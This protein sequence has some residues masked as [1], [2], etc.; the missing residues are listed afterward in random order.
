MFAVVGTYARGYHP[1]WYNERKVTEGLALRLYAGNFLEEAHEL[2]LKDISGRFARLEELNQRSGSKAMHI[3]LCFP[4]EEDFSSDRF[5]RIARD[6]LGLMGLARQPYV[7]YRHVDAGSPHLH[8]VVSKVLPPG[9]RVIDFSRA[10]RRLSQDVVKKVVEMHGLAETERL[11]DREMGI[12][13]NEGRRI[14]YGQ[15]PSTKAIEE[16]LTYVL[17]RYAYTSMDELNSILLQ[18]NVF[19]DTGRP[20]SFMDRKGGLVYQIHDEYG[21][22][23]GGRIPASRLPSKPGRVW[24]AKAFDQNVVQYGLRLPLLRL[25]VELVL[26]ARPGN[27]AAFTRAMRKEGVQV[28]AF[29]NYQGLVHELAFVDHRRKI[30]VMSSGLGDDLSAERIFDRLG[31]QK[32]FELAIKRKPHGVEDRRLLPADKF[33]AVQVLSQEKKEELGH[34]LRIRR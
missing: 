18:Y 4:P 30:A 7:V 22:Y 1:L 20:G 26:K 16:V 5:I 10:P 8:L 29:M 12:A 23:K 27:W 17:P 15:S 13:G 3:A 32:R 25:Q 33:R 31:F 28:T 14:E 11:G 2:T 34:T 6:Y 9:G 24:L 19:A 21:K